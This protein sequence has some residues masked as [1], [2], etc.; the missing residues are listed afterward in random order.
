MAKY[1]K[2][3]G[4]K[5]NL[6]RVINVVSLDTLDT[7]SIIYEHGLFSMCH[8]WCKSFS[9]YPRCNFQVVVTEIDQIL[10]PKS[11]VIVQDTA[12]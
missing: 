9:T 6:Q 2:C 4:Y 7:L 11:M 10:R 1:S 8:D 5:I 3:Y 12:E